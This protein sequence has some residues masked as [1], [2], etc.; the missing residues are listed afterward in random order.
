MGVW[1][2]HKSIFY[3]SYIKDSLKVHSCILLSWSVT[4][5]VYSTELS[6]LCSLSWM[7][8]YQLDGFTLAACLCEDKAAKYSNNEQ[9]K[10]SPNKNQQEGK[11]GGGLTRIWQAH[12]T[13]THTTSEVRNEIRLFG[14]GT[15]EIQILETSI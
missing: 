12:D 13:Q 6:K 11:R 2:M 7:T 8:G 10:G 14:W 3:K 9:Q 4:G 5:L 1:E 15:N